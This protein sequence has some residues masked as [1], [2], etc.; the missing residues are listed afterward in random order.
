MK[1]SL[2]KRSLQELASMYEEFAA[3]HGQASETGDHRKANAQFRR[4]AAVWKELRTRKS[5][6][7]GAL[8][9]LL[10]SANPHVRGWAA[11]HAL[12]SAPQAAEAVLEQLAN[13]PPSIARFNA[14]MVLS[15]WRAGRLTF[16]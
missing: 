14:E 6:G 16:D 15:E 7:S 8:L 3:A 11:S 5:E 2:E 10:G 12:E 9:N 13:G 4:I 1:T